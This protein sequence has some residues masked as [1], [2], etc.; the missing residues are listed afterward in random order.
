MQEPVVMRELCRFVKTRGC[1]IFAGLQKS[2][3]LG[4]ASTEPNPKSTSWRALLVKKTSDDIPG[5]IVF[6]GE[7]AIAGYALNKMCFSFNSAENRDA[8]VRDE[9]G[10]CDRFNVTAAQRL[11]LK[12]RN[13]L[14]LL[15]AGA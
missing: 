10:Y 6:D 2:I 7:K 14:E 5:T 3:T 15:E 1:A 13:V 4:L 12:H 9:D 11:A 8:F